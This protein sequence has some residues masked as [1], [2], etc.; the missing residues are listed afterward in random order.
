MRTSTD[1]ALKL[2]RSLDVLSS[3]FVFVSKIDV[4][5]GRRGLQ[6]HY[7][8]GRAK[9]GNRH[10]VQLTMDTW[11][12]SSVACK[13]RGYYWTQAY[14]P[15]QELHKKLTFPNV[16][17]SYNVIVNPLQTAVTVHCYHKFCLHLPTFNNQ[18]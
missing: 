1:E 10:N 9:V 17:A 4:V 11:I 18:A 5:Q 12:M 13:V 2:Q 7:W 15:R 3:I 14:I 8:F 6:L 16:T